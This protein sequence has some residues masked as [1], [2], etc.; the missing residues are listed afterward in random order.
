MRISIE[1]LKQLTEL[2]DKPLK[3]EYDKGG[4]SI[5]IPVKCRKNSDALTRP[6]KIENTIISQL[7]VYKINEIRF[8][9]VKV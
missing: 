5:T 7:G 8:W 6:L 4:Q 2:I 3:V 1:E 9:I